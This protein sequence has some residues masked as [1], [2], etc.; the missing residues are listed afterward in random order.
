[1]SMAQSSLRRLR[2]M[3]VEVWRLRRSGPARTDDSVPEASDRVER[4][5]ATGAIRIRLAPGRGRWLLVTDDQI[6]DA[7]QP[8]LDDLR[9]VLGTEQCRFGQWSDTADAGVAPDEWSERG[10][11]HVVAFGAPPGAHPSIVEV[12]ALAELAKSG[13]A[14]RSLWLRLRPLLER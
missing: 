7:A 12:P 10:I 8:L 3:G 5:P 6:P 14:R 11:T 13:Q 4:V 2:G 1:M 9:A